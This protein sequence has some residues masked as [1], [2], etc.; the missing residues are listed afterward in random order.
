LQRLRRPRETWG[1]SGGEIVAEVQ[2]NH[3]T[4]FYGQ[5]QAGLAR[6]GNRRKSPNSDS[7]GTVSDP[8]SQDHM[9]TSLRPPTIIL[10]L[11]YNHAD[12]SKTA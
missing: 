7:G 4:E 5:R 1:D 3:V 9:Y 8:S 6:N 10:S 11:L 2:E 12:R